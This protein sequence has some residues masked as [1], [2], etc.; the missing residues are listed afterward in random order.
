MNEFYIVR[1]GL[2]DMNLE[3]RLQ[4][5]TDMELNQTGI[6]QAKKARAYLDV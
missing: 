3:M 6:N 2:T 1:H 4:G 5:R